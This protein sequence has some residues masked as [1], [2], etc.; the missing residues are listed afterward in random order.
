[1]LTITDRPLEHWPVINRVLSYCSSIFCSHLN[2]KAKLSYFDFCRIHHH[3]PALHRRSNAGSNV[4]AYVIITWNIKPWKFSHQKAKPTVKCR[5]FKWLVT[6][7]DALESSQLHACQLS[8]IRR[9]TP[10]IWP[11]LRLSRIYPLILP[12]IITRTSE[13]CILVWRSR[14]IV[15]V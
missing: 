1:M 13:W 9:E 2:D 12:H 6:M 10:A 8:C 15:F 14:W 7:I 4:I 11:P 3:A 5:E